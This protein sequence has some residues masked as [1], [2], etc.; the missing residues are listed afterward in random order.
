MKSM[1]VCLF[2]CAALCAQLAQPCGAQTNVTGVVVDKD[3]KPI[4]SVRCSVSGFP[5]PSGGRIIYSGLRQF[6]FSDNEGH[7]AIP[8]PRSDPLVD[9]QFDEEGG[10]FVV[11][12]GVSTRV[13][14][15]KHA[16]AFLYRVR[17][18]D[19]PVRVVMTEGK[20]LRGRIVE[21]VRDAVLPIPHAEVELQMP[22][23]DAWYQCSKPTD[24]KGE[25]EFRISEP[26]GKSPW[27]LYYAGKRLAVDYAQVTPETVMVLEVSVK[28]TP[29]A[30]RDGPANGSQPI[31]SETNRTSSAAGS[32]R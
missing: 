17:P 12:S 4:A 5:Q 18:A 19:G 15:Y 14:P 9:L 26:P 2:F 13:P 11:T 24:A 7:F 25:F 30:E 27:M 6:V 16:P 8:L 3:G 21:R 32:R 31:R 29:S 10:S 22:Q 23:E 20:V 1:R 28:M